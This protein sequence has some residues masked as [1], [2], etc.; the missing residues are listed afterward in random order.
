MTPY[1][2]P[3]NF[4]WT[5]KNHLRVSINGGTPFIIHWKIGFSIINHPAIG[6]PPAIRKPPSASKPHKAGPQVH[7]TMSQ[8]RCQPCIFWAPPGFRQETRAAT[9]QDLPDTSQHGANIRAAGLWG[10][11][12]GPKNSTVFL[13]LHVFS[14]NWAWLPHYFIQS[15]CKGAFSTTD[16]GWKWV[17]KK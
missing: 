17:E 6:V 1:T 4:F 13:V 10:V 14:R 2:T 8:L 5:Q 12:H 15:Y 7:Q 9:P 11:Q 3:P 16:T